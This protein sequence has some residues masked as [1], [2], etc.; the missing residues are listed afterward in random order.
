MSAG[1]APPWRG[2]RWPGGGQTV[3]LHGDRR[4][5][6]DLPC[7]GVRDSGTLIVAFGAP[8]QGC[9]GHCRTRRRGVLARVAVSVPLRPL[10]GLVVP[11]GPLKDDVEAVVGVDDGDEAH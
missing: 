3:P 10:A 2:E 4:F 11:S 1:M 8:T 9:C 7:G 5:W 6:H